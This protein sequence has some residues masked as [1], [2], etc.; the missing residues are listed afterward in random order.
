MPSLSS[1]EGDGFTNGTIPCLKM[2][3]TSSASPAPP[4][5]EPF[6]LD[7]SQETYIDGSAF[8]SADPYLASAGASVIQHDRGEV[9]KRLTASIP[10]EFPR[11]AAFA[12][13]L[14]AMLTERHYPAGHQPKAVADCASVVTASH[15]GRDFA[16]GEKRTAAGLWVDMRS[17]GIQV[18]KTK[19]HRS[20]GEAKAQGDETDWIG[21]DLADTWAKKAAANYLPPADQ[22]QKRLDFTRSVEAYLKGVSRLL[23]LWKP[24]PRKSVP[25]APRQPIQK[26]PHEPVFHG[27]F[28]VWKCSS[29]FKVVKNRARLMQS[30]CKKIPRVHMDFIKSSSGL[31]HRLFHA[32]YSLGPGSVTFCARCG[33]Y[34]EL[35]QKGLGKAC[36]GAADANAGFRNICWSAGRHPVSKLPVEAPT[37]IGGSPRFLPPASFG[38]SIA[39]PGPLGRG[40][41]RPSVQMPF[42][43]PVAP[44]LVRAA[45]DDPDASDFGDFHEP[46]FEEE[47]PVVPSFSWSHPD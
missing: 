42:S 23:Y 35:K 12:E 7:P 43:Y 4:E 37:K 19:A 3:S 32:R 31:G 33:L 1:P 39:P 15:R 27:G 10:L 22:Q 25:R 47:P 18:R 44:A 11:Q 17:S 14:A 26:A 40:A 21:N 36:R 2:S 16:V 13:H 6:T 30:A 24:I 29:C 38:D 20:Y 8:F 9:T 34:S 46:V 28:R 5:G 41:A 45:F